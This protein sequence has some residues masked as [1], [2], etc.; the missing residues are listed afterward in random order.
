[1]MTPAS[2]RPCSVRC[3]AISRTR[4]REHTRFA[5]KAAS[6]TCVAVRRPSPP[7]FT[8]NAHCAHARSGRSPPATICTASRKS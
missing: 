3:V 8:P 6:D 1:M 2:P 7:C 5:T 4:G